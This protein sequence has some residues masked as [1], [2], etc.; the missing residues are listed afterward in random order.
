MAEPE[1][2][3]K[4]EGRPNCESP[5]ECNSA[6]QQIKNLR[7]GAVRER[8][9]IT[10]LQTRGA[11]EGCSAELYSAVS[12]ICNLRGVAEPGRSAEHEGPPNC[13]RPAEC[14]S[15]I[16]QIKNLRYYA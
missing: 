2:L 16:Q 10:H 7:Y 6:I 11:A 8:E 14:N 15:A 3:A 13:E 5:A 9:A 4:S 12:Q 1:R